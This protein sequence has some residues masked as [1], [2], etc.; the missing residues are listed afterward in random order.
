MKK[1]EILVMHKQPVTVFA[2]CPFFSEELLD[3]PWKNR[4]WQ[5]SEHAPRIDGK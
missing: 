4:L 2:V 3:S 1:I 5:L